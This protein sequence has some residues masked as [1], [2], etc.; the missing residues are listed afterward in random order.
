M[1]NAFQAPPPRPAAVPLPPI[2]LLPPE[3][4]DHPEAGG[5]AKTLSVPAV[6]STTESVQGRT[7][8]VPTEPAADEAADG[9]PTEEAAPPTQRWPKNLG[10][11]V[12]VVATILVVVVI[13]ALIRKS[14]DNPSSGS[15]TPATVTHK[16]APSTTAPAASIP[17]SNSVSSGFKAASA[18]LD[19]AN[20]TVTRELAG[21]ASQSVAQI[22]Q[23]V[24]PY[25]TALNAFNFET[26]T[27]TWPASLQ[28]P[29]EDLTLRTNE[30]IHY[31]SSVSTASPATLPSW[32]AQFHALA[33][34]AQEEDN[35]LRKDLGM[36][37]TSSYPTK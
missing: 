13:V 10:K 11:I 12:L 32:F 27:L 33:R 14:A 35:A 5:Q 34:V 4:D 31:L 30:L 26:H 17:A 29:S 23:E 3:P 18:N 20:A 16:S 15:L 1:S 6:A 21:G 24:G 37:P 9:V 28:V 19:A 2:R 36:P 22:T 7:Q 25:E 8:D